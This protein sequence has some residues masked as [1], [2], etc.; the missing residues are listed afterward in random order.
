E[1]LKSGAEDPHPRELRDR[2]A[3]RLLDAYAAHA[4]D[5]WPWWE[6]V[7]T[8]DNAK[9]SHALI[10]SGQAMNRR[11]MIDAGLASL[12]RLIEV[13]TADP[14]DG[15]QTDAAAESQQRT[16]CPGPH[17]SIIGNAGWLRRDGSRARF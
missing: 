13:Q 5:E 6:D 9:L 10:V 15:T 1:Y 4:T 12:R 7:V 8:Y 2:L 3:Q 17:L 14:A 16:P 11:D